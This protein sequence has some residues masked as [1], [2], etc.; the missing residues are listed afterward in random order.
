MSYMV[1][2]A[3]YTDEVGE[4]LTVRG[5][6]VLGTTADD[7]RRIG[8][9]TAMAEEDGWNVDR[10]CYPWVAYLGARFDCLAFLFM[11]SED[12]E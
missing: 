3:N 7:L 2:G 9:T 6:A 11:H 12:E 8:Y 1:R 5:R 10:H 4:L